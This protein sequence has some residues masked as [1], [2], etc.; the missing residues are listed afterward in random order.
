MHKCMRV[1]VYVCMYERMYTIACMYM[2][3][4]MYCM[5]V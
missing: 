2:Y 5:Y 1:C 4:N 3:V